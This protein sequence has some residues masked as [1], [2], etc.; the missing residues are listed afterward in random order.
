MTEG[1]CAPLLLLQPL[2][3]V[4]GR[5]EI[6]STG[7]SNLAVPSIQSARKQNCFFRNCFPTTAHLSSSEAG[8][9]TSGVSINS[10]NT[11]IDLVMCGKVYPPP[12]NDQ[13]L[14]MYISNPTP[15]YVTE[16]QITHSPS[17]EDKQSGRWMMILFILGSPVFLT[18][19]A[20]KA[21]HIFSVDTHKEQDTYYT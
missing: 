9:Q 19:V 20:L 7:G 8:I 11:E 21:T 5:T 14:T 18:P 17:G 12:K 16:A 15:S 13:E 3:G 1:V 10:L 6:E 4:S 2:A